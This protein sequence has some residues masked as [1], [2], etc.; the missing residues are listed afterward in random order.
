MTIDTSVWYKKDTGPRLSPSMRQI[1]EEWSNIPSD[2]LQGHLHAV[3][4]K[5]WKYGKYPCIGLWMFLLP[6]IAE[7]PQFQ[8]VVELARQG[9]TVPD[10]GSGLGQNL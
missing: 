5:A 6:G 9:G 3:R 1:F 10:L 2:E 7:F 4:D 8:R